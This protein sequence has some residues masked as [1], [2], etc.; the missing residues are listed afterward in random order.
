MRISTFF[1]LLV[2]ILVAL[3][4][5][6]TRSMVMYVQ[7]DP[8]P[9]P[10]V[11]VQGQPTGLDNE[12]MHRADGNKTKGR[13]GRE[14]MAKGRE[15]EHALTQPVP[16]KPLLTE[17]E[18]K[19]TAEGS[20]PQAARQEAIRIA[21]ERVTEYMR[22]RFP[23][24]R[25]VPTTKFMVEHRLVDDG[26]SEKKEPKGAIAT[27]L[28]SPDE[29]TMHTLSI[30]LREPQVEQLLSE[31]RHERGVERL[32]EAGHVLSGLIVMLIAFVGYVRLDDWTKGYFSLPLKLGALTLAVAGPVVMWWLV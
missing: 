7:A 26:N 30:D 32:W 2:L 1:V 21:S 28:T 3:G 20:S 6:T 13:R 9:P 25:Y 4:I 8:P 23:D 27:S 17:E 5:R 10:E 11:H 29:W 16:S 24:F 12:E 31:D 22:K 14:T 18:R 19:V 15:Q